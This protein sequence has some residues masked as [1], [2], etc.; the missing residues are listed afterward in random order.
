VEAFTWRSDWPQQGVRHWVGLRKNPEAGEIIHP[1]L[2][3]RDISKWHAQFADTYIIYTYHGVD[4]SR[5][6]AVEEYLRGFSRALRDRATDQKWYELQQPQMAYEPYFRGP[7][8]VYQEINR[9][10]AF[11]YDV[12]EPAGVFVNNKVFFIPNAPKALLAL[13]NSTIASFFLHTLS[14]VPPGGFLALQLNIINPL[15]IPNWTDAEQ[16]ILAT[17]ADYV[18]WL[19]RHGAATGEL[20]DEAGKAL[21]AGYFVQWANALVYELFFPEAL[22]RAGLHF[23]RLTQEAMLR[24]LCEIERGK[25]L[26]ELR[27]KFEACF[28]PNHPLRQNLFALDSIEEIRIIEGKA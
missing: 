11:A 4:I 18:L 13:M 17:L 1:F 27:T 6:P 19:N 15:P 23:F 28:A 20:G 3:G 8:L 16:E 14:G 2:R 22:H 25:E 24:P 7:K 9:T 5:F 21:L 12:A 10:D 26:A